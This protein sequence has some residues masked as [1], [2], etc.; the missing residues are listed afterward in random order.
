MAKVVYEIAK[1]QN[2]QR[3]MA[4]ALLTI[5]EINQNLKQLTEC[6]KIYQSSKDQV[7]NNTQYS[8]LCLS[9]AKEYRKLGGTKNQAQSLQYLEIAFNVNQNNP[10]EPSKR[11]SSNEQLS[12]NT[13]NEVI[14]QYYQEMGQVLLGESKE[15]QAIDC[16]RKSLD[17]AKKMY[18]LESFNTMECYLNLAQLLEKK[19]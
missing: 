17:I 7:L 11:T 18:G 16:Y 2:C 12:N 6:L 15:N 14:L 3:L 13:N 4:V 19:G 1:A 5:G 10:S 9:L 8:Q